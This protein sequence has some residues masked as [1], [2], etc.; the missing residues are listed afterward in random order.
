MDPRPI[1][2]LD[3]V[4][5]R[6]GDTVAVQ[7]V[8]A[9]VPRGALVTFVGPSGCGKTTLLRLVGGF[10]E[11]DSGRIILDGEVVNRHPPNRRA[12]GMVFQNYALFPHLSVFENIA[13]GLRIRRSPRDEVRRRVTE[14]L[15]VVQLQGLGDRRPSQLSGGQQ[16]RVALARALILRP[17]VL[18]LDEP[19]SNLDAHLRLAM[20]DELR[21]LQ[22]TL[23][24]TIIFVTHD[25]EEAMA[26]SDRILVV[27]GGRI[28]QAGTP[29]E[30]YEHPATEFVA[31][32]VGQANFVAATL[33]RAGQ[34]SAPAV[35]RTGLG[36]FEVAPGAG[37]QLEGPVWV[38][39]RP[40]SIDL[41]PAGVGAVAGEV[42][43]A[44]YVGAV[45]RYTVRARGEHLLVDQF[46]PQRRE[47]LRE[48]AAVSLALPRRVH[49]I[50]RTA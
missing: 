16:Q 5:K 7:E 40:E 46:D 42:V 14:M 31:R 41:L 4:T 23:A 35:A 33:G 36:E 1:L 43:S 32:F 17:K 8:S 13:Y 21:R 3:A 26:I 39:L 6:Y 12:T 28:E 24:L 30:I 2:V 25:Q 38:I 15:A 37:S 20:R 45:V 44:T 11:P 49:W 27:R 22:R 50:P 34:D 47:P 29:Q 19:L 10:V 9:E 48:G 18:L